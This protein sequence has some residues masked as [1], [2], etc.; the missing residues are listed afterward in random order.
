MTNEE[1]ATRSLRNA[2]ECLERARDWLEL[3]R[4]GDG[5]IKEI[6]TL[7]E[8]VTELLCQ[9]PRVRCDALIHPGASPT[10]SQCLLTEGHSGP[11]KI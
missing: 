9:F 4:E 1:R 5:R 3:D 8:H 2:R 6:E 10:A 11:H 7:S